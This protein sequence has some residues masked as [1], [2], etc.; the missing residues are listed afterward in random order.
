MDHFCRNSL[1]SIPALSPQHHWPHRYE[2][3]FR[4]HCFA[5]STQQTASMGT[6][7]SRMNTI[8]NH[9]GGYEGASELQQASSPVF[10]ALSTPGPDPPHKVSL[11]ATQSPHS[12]VL[13]TYPLSQPAPSPPDNPDS[14][15][16][17]SF[18]TSPSLPKYGLPRIAA[19]ETPKV[20]AKR[21]MSAEADSQEGPKRFKTSQTSPEEDG[22]K[23]EK[24]EKQK[25]WSFHIAAMLAD[26]LC[27]DR[28]R[29]LPVDVTSA[30]PTPPK[31][32]LQS[33]TEYGPDYTPIS[34]ESWNG[35]ELPQVWHAFSLS[36]ALMLLKLGS[37]PLMVWESAGEGCIAERVCREDWLRHGV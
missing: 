17:V 27:W 1:L 13:Q 30:S 18:R 24:E 25:D 8:L 28:C 37:E 11:R 9:R 3:A 7:L 34:T 23:E 29:N 5:S 20:K 2:L 19:S 6:Q 15:T 32:W 12:S 14:P 31:F 36:W 16:N 35:Q 21:A 10:P 4:K 33:H 22:A 26:D